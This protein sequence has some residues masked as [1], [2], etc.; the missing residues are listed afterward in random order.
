MDNVKEH[1]FWAE[2]AENTEIFRQGTI[3]TCFYIIQ[4]GSVEI[5]S[6][7]EITKIL[8]ANEGFGELALLYEI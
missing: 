3:G 7:E 8:K 4:T 2:M 6:D 1:M 5:K